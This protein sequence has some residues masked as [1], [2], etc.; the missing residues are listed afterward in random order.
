MP[1]FKYRTKLP[2][3]DDPDI[4]EGIYH[5]TSLGLPLTKA[6]ALAGIGERTATEWYAIGCEQLAILQDG[7]E[8][9]SHALYALAVKEAEAELV[10][11]AIGVVNQAME[12]PKGW[13][14]AMTLLERRFPKDFG[15][16]PQRLEIEHRGPSVSVTVIARLDAST[17]TAI[18]GLLSHAAQSIGGGGDIIEGE[19]GAQLQA[20]PPPASP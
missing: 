14:P 17:L 19:G 15:R 13:L 7:E 12:E 3:P 2:R 4:I 16:G 18:A 11:R 6:A 8:P 9:G 20:L 5:G 10:S 1:A